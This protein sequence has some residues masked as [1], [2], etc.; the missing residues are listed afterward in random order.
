MKTL[1]LLFVSAGFSNAAEGVVDLINPDNYADQPVPAYITRDNTPA[2][3]PITDR[4]ATLGRVLFYDKRLSRDDTV[5]CSSCHQ[6]SRGFSDLA[7]ASNGVAGTTGRHSMRLVNARFSAEE[8]FFWD[9]RAVTLED[10]TTRPIRDHVEM[11]FSGTDGDPDFG[12]LVVKLSAIEEYKVLFQAVYGDLAIT[13]ERMQKAIAQFVRSIQSFDSPFDEGRAI[14]GA[15]GPPFPNFTASENAGK[16]LFLAGPGPGGGAGCAGCHRPPEFDIDPNSGNNGVVGAIGG[17][18]DFT[19][20]RSPS[21][22]DSVGPAG[23]SNGGFMHTGQ[24]ATLE[25]VIAHYNAIPA[26]VQGL[27]PRLI[28][29][30]G[31]PQRLNLSA[32]Q[33]ADLAAFLRTLTGSAIYTDPKW[34]DPFDAAGQ[35]SLVVLPTDGLEMTFSGTGESREATVAMS[36]V[37]NV[38]YFFQW[39]GDL[40]EWDSLPVTADATGRIEVVTGAPESAGRGFYRFAYQSAVE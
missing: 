15:N 18:T 7:V 6:Q 8:Q 2:D 4:G 38:D 39:S 23:A 3:N 17:G 29:P 34:S 35:L 14:V 30:G 22:R 16:Q 21:L 33:Q 13:E 11:G 28:R 9:E 37:P 40:D 5:S 32:Q 12:D 1:L 27:D 10:Q 36:A 26:V 25:Q 24:F 19:V 31:Q 20:T